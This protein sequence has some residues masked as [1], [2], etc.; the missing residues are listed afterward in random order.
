MADSTPWGV[1]VMQTG[2]TPAVPPLLSPDGDLYFCSSNSNSQLVKMDA[3]GRQIFSVPVGCGVPM[4][5]SPDGNILDGGA[6]KLNGLDGHV[7][8]S[9]STHMYQV[10]GLAGDIAGN[11]YLAGICSGDAQCVEKLDPSGNLIYERSLQGPLAASYLASIAADASGDAYVTGS[12]A[13]SSFLA[14]LDTKGGILAY[15][16][17]NANEAGATVGLDPAGNPEV[18]MVSSNS[19]QSR[20]LKYDSALSTILFD[21]PLSGFVPLEMLVG[22]DGAA[23]LLGGTDSVNL[24]QLH[25]TLLARYP[26]GQRA[27]SL[28]IH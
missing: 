2:F 6:V 20:V 12:A 23:V 5:W 18:L 21:T 3:S 14:K 25:P 19:N 1:S 27:F 15:V 26:L 28:C 16:L 9:T 22:S 10:V 17:G 13:N 24:A 11:A 4:V 8:Y 7:L